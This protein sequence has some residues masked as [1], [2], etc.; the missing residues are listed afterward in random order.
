MI[1]DP[2]IIESIQHGKTDILETALQQ[3]PAL[4]EADAKEGLSLLLFAAYCH[5]HAAVQLIKQY[6]TGLNIYEAVCT[7]ELEIAQTLLEA[8]P[9][10]LNAPSFCLRHRQLPAR[11]SAAGQR[12]RRQCPPAG[13]R[14]GLAFRRSPRRHRAGKTTD[15]TRRR[16]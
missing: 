8:S 1:A 2:G 5:N 14:Y 3:D 6:R 9:E 16:H 10:A 7:G 15:P 12:R 13:R 11:L 4:A